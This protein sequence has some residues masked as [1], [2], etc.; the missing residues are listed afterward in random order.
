MS[1]QALLD[2][3]FVESWFRARAQHLGGDAGALRVL[4]VDRMSRG[5]SRQTWT[6]DVVLDGARERRRFIVRRDHEA[7]SVIASSLFEEYEVYR[8]LDG[9]RVPVARALWYEDDPALMPDGRPAYVRELVDGDWRLPALDN[10]APVGDAERIRLS[11]E[12]LDKLVLVHAVDWQ[13]MGFGELLSVPTSPG[14]CALD[15]ID[16]CL[17][18]LAGYDIEPSPVLAEAVAS[19]RARRP[20][21]CERIVLCKGTNGLGEEVWR[22]GRIVALSDWEMAILG[23]PAYDFAQCQEMIP[24]IVRDRRRLWGL[25]EALDYYAE[26]SGTVV[27]MDRVAYYRELYGLLQFTYAEH[28]ASLVRGRVDAPLRF[29]WTATEVAFRSE[30]RLARQFA[31]HLMRDGFA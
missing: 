20:R 23:D 25:P 5:V 13:A 8:R 4:G 16:D 14:D 11:K 30:L 17:V 10:H 3:A 19:L 18:R 22:D 27:T 26:R 15:L 1:A 29:M 7:G 12:H 21:D 28:A 9:S 24:D 6:V 2:G 31:G